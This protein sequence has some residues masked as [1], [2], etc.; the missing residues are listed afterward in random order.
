[1]IGGKTP[2]HLLRRQGV[3]TPA[4][5]TRIRGPRL[6][7]LRWLR[8]IRWI[9]RLRRLQRCYGRCTLPGIRRFLLSTSAVQFWLRHGGRV[10][11]PAVPSEQGDAN[12]VK[13]GSYGYRD[14]NGLFRRVNYIADANGFRATVDTNEPGTEP[15]AS[16]DVV[17]NASPVVPPIPGG[18]AAQNTFGEGAGAPG[19][20]AYAGFGGGGYGPS[21]SAAG[22]FGYGGYGRNGY[23]PNGP[24]IS[25]HA[26][27][28][29]AQQGYGAVGYAPGGYGPAGY[30]GL[31][32]GHQGFRRR[33]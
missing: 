18:A 22:A 3:G 29:H 17:F 28:G 16:A 20:N 24:A 25:G 26:Y 33:R 14:V 19:Y 21:S 23:P 31:V 10:R 30:G 11:Q 8:W 12:N 7:W 6:W 27:G 1:M 9:R 5:L 2:S 4:P 15:G 32:A 13:T